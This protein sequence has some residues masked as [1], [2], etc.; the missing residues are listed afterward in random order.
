MRTRAITLIGGVA[1]L[2]VACTT[3][4]EGG[5][6]NRGSGSETDPVSIENAFITP[7]NVEGL[8]ALQVGD[9]AGFRYIVSNISDTDSATFTGITTDVA[10]SAEMTPPGPKTIAPQSE[11]NSG[12]D[13]ADLAPGDPA[14]TTTLRG[15][16]ENAEPGQSFSVTFTFADRDPIEIMVPVEACPAA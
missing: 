8:C 6:P 16:R 5:S 2:A 14:F 7:Q 4:P 9:D 13:G 1:L 15:L 10:E 11:I 12:V 3:D